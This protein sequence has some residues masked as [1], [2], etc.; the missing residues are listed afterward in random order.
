LGKEI[1]ARVVDAVGVRPVGVFVL[2]A[3]TLP[4][5][6]SGKLRRA[7]AAELVSDRVG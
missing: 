1:T 4:K 2:S 5:T 6:P 7:A 3:G